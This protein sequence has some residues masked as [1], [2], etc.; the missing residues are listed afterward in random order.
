MQVMFFMI[1]LIFSLV[2]ITVSSLI[3]NS[4]SVRLSTR[5]KTLFSINNAIGRIK[6]LICFGGMDIY[7][8]C[9]ECFCSAEFP[10]FE[11][12]TFSSNKEYDKV[13]EDN[14]NRIS[15]SFSLTKDDK[16]LLSQFGSNL[17]TTDITGQIAHTELYAQLFSERLDMVKSEELK[18]SKLYRVLGFSLGCAVSLLI[19]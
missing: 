6:T 14:V 3:G 8:V 12:E 16:E 2:L 11:R 10:L 19:V 5:R 1:K 7:R 18:K 13:F 15:R 17:G 4:F 9:Q